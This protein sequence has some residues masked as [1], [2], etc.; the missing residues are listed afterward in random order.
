MCHV[1][2]H[3]HPVPHGT[4]PQHHILVLVRLDFDLI[5]WHSLDC[6]LRQIIRSSH[7]SLRQSHLNNLTVSS[8]IVAARTMA[9]HIFAAGSNPPTSSADANVD[10]AKANLDSTST[11]SSGAEATKVQVTSHNQYKT[12]RLLPSHLPSTPLPLFKEW[13]S[14]ALKPTPP[15]PSVAEPEAMAISTSTPSGIPST[16]MVLLKSVDERGFI[17]YTNYTSR[18]SRELEANPYAS[19]A[20]Y[21][22]EVSR[23]VRAIGKVE[24]VSREDSEAYFDSRPKGSQIGAWVSEQSSVVGEETLEERTKE[25]EKRFEGKKVEC[26]P[27]WGGWRIVPL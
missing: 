4:T 16:R 17:F 8:R 1:C 12:P 26:P 10:P 18:K 7:R 2:G 3:C 11:S 9:S 23:S 25:M 21:W 6:M 15:T 24:K 22:R 13:F 14:S 27:H 19:M 5:T 20:I